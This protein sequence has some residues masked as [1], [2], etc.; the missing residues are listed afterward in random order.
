V[1]EEALSV[2][3]GGVRAVIVY[4]ARGAWESEV[5]PGQIV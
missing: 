3:G 4:S 2:P 1:W 5:W